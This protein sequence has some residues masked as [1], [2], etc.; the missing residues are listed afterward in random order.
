MRLG[1]GRLKG[2]HDAIGS[3]FGSFDF[4]AFAMLKSSLRHK[5]I[6]DIFLCSEVVWVL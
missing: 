6:S 5:Y 1:I 3:N 2:K 4:F